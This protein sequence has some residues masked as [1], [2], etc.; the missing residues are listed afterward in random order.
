MTQNQMEGPCQSV[1]RAG[2]ARWQVLRAHEAP[3]LQCLPTYGGSP[4]RTRR[5]AHSTLRSAP[6]PPFPMVGTHTKPCT[7]L[8]I[9]IPPRLRGSGTW[10]WVPLQKCEKEW[11]P[12]FVWGTQGI[13]NTSRGEQMHPFLALA[14]PFPSAPTRHGLHLTSFCFRAIRLT[15]IGKHM[16]T[17]ASGNKWQE[18]LGLPLC[19]RSQF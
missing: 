16:G 7:R 4:R 15:C 3:C 12:R 13:H 2:G 1:C 14:L 11:D 6:A 10:P 18:Q 8:W 9:C 19:T 5:G 17:N